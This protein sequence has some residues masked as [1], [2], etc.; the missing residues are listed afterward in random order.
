MNYFLSSDVKNSLLKDCPYILH[1]PSICTISY[2][3]TFLSQNYTV[4]FIERINL[5]HATQAFLRSL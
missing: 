1:T 4:Y 2:Q 5:L 3:L